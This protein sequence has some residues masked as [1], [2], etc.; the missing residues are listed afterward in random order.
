MVVKNRAAGSGFSIVELMVVIVLIGTLGLLV[1]V[2][3]PAALVDA[4][5]KE[6]N[7]DTS[8]IARYLERRYIKNAQTTFPSYPTTVSIDSELTDTNGSLVADAKLA[9]GRTVSSI[10][11]AANNAAQTPTKDQYIYQPLLST[12]SL[13]TSSSDTQPCVRFIIWYRLERSSQIV[14]IEST[15]QQ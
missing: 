14:S 5:D 12:G 6:R 1:A 4:R 2:N 15:H 10:V 13:C 9:P 11:P 3:W 8:A 7:S